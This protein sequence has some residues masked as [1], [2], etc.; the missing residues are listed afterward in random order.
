MKV[1]ARQVGDV[2]VIDVQG[3]MTLGAGS[4]LMRDMLRELK[5][6][7]QKKILVNLAQMTYADDSFIG[8][9]VSGF[10]TITNAGGKLKL[11][12]LP[13]NFCATLQM[14]RLYTVFDVQ[15]DEAIGIRSFQD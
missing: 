11:L 15:T 3:M 4:L 7:N 12:A 5:L 1:E 2:T 8:E 6:N 9:L 14:A 13:E 10:T